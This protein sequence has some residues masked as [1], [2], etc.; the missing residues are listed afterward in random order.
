MNRAM[1]EQG[2][3]TPRCSRDKGMCCA[4]QTEVREGTASGSPRS[5]PAGRCLPQLGLLTGVSQL[6]LLFFPPTFLPSCSFPSF[7]RARE[8]HRR[9]SDAVVTLL[10][11]PKDFVLPWEL[12]SP[13]RHAVT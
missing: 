5:V 6:S 12:L 9:G 10:P 3:C 8:R 13:R 4:L 1:G 7:P 2:W 11:K